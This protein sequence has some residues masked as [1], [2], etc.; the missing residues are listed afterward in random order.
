M[1]FAKYPDICTL[2]AKMACLRGGFGRHSK[3]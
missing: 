2:F 1:I 3:F